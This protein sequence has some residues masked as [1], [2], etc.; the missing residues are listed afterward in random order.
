MSFAQRHAEARLRTT[1]VIESASVSAISRAEVELSLVVVN[2]MAGSWRTQSV[3][4]PLP[5]APCATLSAVE[6]AVCSL[7]LDRPVI[8]GA[9]DEEL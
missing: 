1:D 2:I 4:V 5:D 6:A 8:H 7:L 3:R 9:P